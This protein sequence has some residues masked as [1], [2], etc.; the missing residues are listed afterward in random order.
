MPRARTKIFCITG[1]LVCDA[2]EYCSE[3]FW[4][5]VTLTLAIVFVITA[6]H[7]AYTATDTAAAARWAK[8]VIP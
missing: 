2:S 3:G 1:D 8:T 4:Q 7:L 5:R 6:S